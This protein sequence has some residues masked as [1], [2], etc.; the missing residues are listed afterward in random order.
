MTPWDEVVTSLNE[1]ME[2]IKSTL[3]E[4]GVGDF[5]YHVDEGE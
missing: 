4:G 2:Q 1:Q 3:A 5:R